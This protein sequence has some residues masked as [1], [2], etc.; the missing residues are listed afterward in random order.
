MQIKAAEQVQQAM[1]QN[2]RAPE[3]M[4]HMS[5]CKLSWLRRVS[6]LDA[7]AGLVDWTGGDEFDERVDKSNRLFLTVWQHERNTDWKCFCDSL[8]RKWCK[9]RP[10]LR[11]CA[12]YVLAGGT[13]SIINITKWDV[14]QAGH[15]RCY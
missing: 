14:R 9:M 12:V 3:R 13:I 15:E 5:A 7:G 2:V 1:A 6:A 10:D 4:P 8:Q 11:P